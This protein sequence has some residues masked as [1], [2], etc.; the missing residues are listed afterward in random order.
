MGLT[1]LAPY[2]DTEDAVPAD[3]KTQVEEVIAGLDDGSIE[4]GVVK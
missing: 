1:G 4:T 3:V 2:H